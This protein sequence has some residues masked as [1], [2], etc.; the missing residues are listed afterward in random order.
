MDDKLTHHIN[1]GTLSSFK[2]GKYSRRLEPL[3]NEKLLQIHL[4]S[5][6]RLT[7]F[8]E[9]VILNYFFTSMFLY[10]AAHIYNIVDKADRLY[11]FQIS[12][13][14]QKYIF[15]EIFI[16]RIKETLAAATLQY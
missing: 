12:C 1:H 15:V 13:Q 8:H 5:Y 11:F 16:K 2:Q 10:T 7:F 4:F 6:I 9:S 14:L 3:P